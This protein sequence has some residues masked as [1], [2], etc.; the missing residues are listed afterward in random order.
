MPTAVGSE[1]QQSV[2]AELTG[3]FIAIAVANPDENGD[4]G[5]PRTCKHS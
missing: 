3:A 5:A 4:I 1:W 2:A